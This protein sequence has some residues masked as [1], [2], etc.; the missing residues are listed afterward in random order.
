MKP[1]VIAFDIGGTKTNAAAFGID[2]KGR[3]IELVFGRF[4]N[5]EFGSAEAV[6]RAFLTLVP[7]TESLAIAVAAPVNNNRAVL[8]NIDWKIDA[9]V[10]AKKY[11][12]KRAVLLNDLEAAVIG[13]GALNVSDFSVLQKGRARQGNIV[14]VAPGTGLGEA[15]LVGTCCTV[16]A[17]EGGHADF[18]P[19]NKT[20]DALL[21]FLRK[22]YGHVSYERVLSGRGIGDI[23][24]FLMSGREVPPRTKERFNVD[25]KAAVI[26]G[27]AMR[28]G[29]DKVCKKALE[30]FMSVLG[31]EA[32][33]MALKT[34]ST[35]GVFIGG[36]IAPKI[37][38]AL[39]KDKA[40]IRA[41]HAKGR[42]R[43]FM[44]DIPVKAVMNDKCALYGAALSGL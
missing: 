1:R 39:K 31:A 20:E 40:F 18:A 11:G 14:M 43:A 44:K 7:K 12:F 8:V 21:L 41:F 17:T 4:K 23:Y 42:F 3:L 16:V 29:G 22:K 25:D 36:G 27:E 24:D 35:G 33:N 30:V 5:S 2:K 19:Q 38:T 34:L 32:G 37:I 6:V 28:K 9:N 13:V 15:A 26:S 10:I